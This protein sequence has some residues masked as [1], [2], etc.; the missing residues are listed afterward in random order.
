MEVWSS[1][2]EMRYAIQP[3]PNHAWQRCFLPSSMANDLSLDEI[4]NALNLK[5]I[6]ERKW[7]IQACLSK[8]GDGL[9]DRLW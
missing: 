4:Q 3:I 2:Q 8:S 1:N 5:I 6:R 7:T 9:K